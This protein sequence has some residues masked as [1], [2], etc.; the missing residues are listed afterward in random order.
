MSAAFVYLSR[1]TED[2]RQ[3]LRCR[4]RHVAESVKEGLT[5]PKSTLSRPMQVYSNFLNSGII[6]CVAAQSLQRP[7]TY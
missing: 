5:I 7:E 2:F 6:R 1:H 3:P 4:I